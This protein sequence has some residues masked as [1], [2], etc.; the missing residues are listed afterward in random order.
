MALVVVSGHGPCRDHSRGLLAGNPADVAGVVGLSGSGGFVVGGF[1]LE[2]VLVLVFVLVGGFFAAAEIAL[3]SLRDGQVR[4]L[5]SLGRRGRRVE[6]LR[7]D[8][9]RFLSAVQVGVTF[10]GF[11]ASSFGGATIA[12]RLE[13]ALSGWGLPRAVAT[14]V[15]LVVV[16]VLV[17]YFS[18]VLG[19]LVPKRLA[20][21]K[22][23]TVA[24]FS[25]GVLDRLASAFRPV[26]WLLSR[27]TDAVVRLLGFDPHARQEEVSEEELRDLVRSHDGLSVVERRLMSDAFEAGDRVVGEIMV[28]R[29]EVDFLVASTSLRDAVEDVSTRPHSRYPV[30]TE[31][32]DDVV[33]FVHVRDL[34]TA[35]RREREDDG[36]GTSAPAAV[37]DIVRPVT[38]FPGSKPLLDALGE[39]RRGGGHLAL[40]IDEYGGTDGIVT[41]E[42]LVEEIVGEI[43]DEYDPTA[44]RSTHRKVGNAVEV[45]GLL[46][47]DEVAEHV[48]VEFPEGPFE[49][50]AGYV[51]NE[52]GRT[53]AEGDTIDRSGHRFTVTA[54]D[55]NRIDRIRIEPIG[56]A[57]ADPQT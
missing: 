27:S 13:P 36:A 8:S 55:A 42:D 34:M 37:G 23:E 16:T 39:M 33:G 25:A 45:N 44:G 57:A 15:A 47:P 29:T 7:S 40:V 48:A 18:L 14:T 20:L 31:S 38:S 3:V 41:V 1:G 22:P 53:A 51:L 50:V 32:P 2:V 11:F 28:P 56:S 46:R 26:I 35:L 19:E 21:Q 54:M 12:L 9:N 30:M 43:W 24:L 4:R 5:A 17:S 49:T 52:L 10:S 6:R